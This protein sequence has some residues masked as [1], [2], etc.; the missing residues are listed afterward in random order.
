MS[1]VEVRWRSL[2][3]RGRIFTVDS[4]EKPGVD[5]GAAVPPLQKQVKLEDFWEGPRPRGP[6]TDGFSAESTV[7]RQVNSQLPHLLFPVIIQEVRVDLVNHLKAF[8]PH[9]LT[10]DILV[11]PVH[12]GEAAKHV[13]QV[14][15][16]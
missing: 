15:G 5:G 13:P 11:D 1:V 3:R 12:Q 6:L 9:P 4:A 14:V 8:V 10:N 7:V 2:R 16:T